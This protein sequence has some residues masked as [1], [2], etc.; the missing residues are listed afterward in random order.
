MNDLLDKNNNNKDNRK[1]ILDNN[2]IME[3]KNFE[4]KI[5]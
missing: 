2:E 3:N 5:I 4:N 1:E